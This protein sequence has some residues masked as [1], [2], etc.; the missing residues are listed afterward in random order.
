MSKLIA[1]L[2]KTG[3]AGSTILSESDMF[4][5]QDLIRTSLPIINI[6]YSG[7]VDGGFG[8]G[9]TVLAGESKTFKTALAL[10]CLK[11]YL[12]KY[13]DGIGVLYDSEGGCNPQYMKSF[14]IDPSR[15]KR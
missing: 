6:A 9:L 2:L 7:R 3:S 10:Y 5:E 12:D 15:R 13:K 4:K 1:K 14:G 11:A 8:S